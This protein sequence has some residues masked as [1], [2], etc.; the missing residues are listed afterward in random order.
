MFDFNLQLFAEGETTDVSTATTT[1]ENV[2]GAAQESQPESLYLVTDPRTGRKSISAA[3]PEPTEPAETKTDEPPVQDE[4]ESQ[5]TEPTEPTE[6]KPAEPAATES[7]AEKQPEPLIHTEPYTLDELN[8][9]IAQGNVNE[10]RI[11]QQYQLQYAQYQQ[12]QARRQQQYQQQ[13]QALQ[14]QAQQQQLEQQKRMFADIDKAATDQ[15]MKALGITQDDID[16]AEYS[17]DDAVK[18]KVA[19]FNTAKS[20]YKEQ[21]IGAIQQQQM[22]TQAAQNEQR[23]IYQS[24]VDFTQQKQ[25]E[26][27]HFADINQLMGSYYQTMPYKD[28]AVIGD[29][30]KALQGGNINPTQ[31]K[32]LEGYYDKCRTAYYAKANDLTKQPKKVP[33]PKVEQPGTGA[34]APAKPIDFTQMRNMTVRERRAFIAGLSGR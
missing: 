28:A 4:P 27:P 20:Y 2:A 33:V 16:T 29:A 25:A 11:P 9:A 12:E 31:C 5:P 24:I 6:T 8:T 23:A 13:Q 7:A 19:H 30:I 15:A 10:S 18:Q 1:N 22:R 26:E 17:D 34:K 3:K 21:L 14:M 32:V